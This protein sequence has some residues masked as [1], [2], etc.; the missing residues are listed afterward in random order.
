MYYS[1][2][3]SFCSDIYKEAFGWDLPNMHDGWLEGFSSP[4]R[5]GNSV[6]NIVMQY[7]Q[8]PEGKKSWGLEADET[9]RD[10]DQ[11]L[12][13]MQEQIRPGD[14]IYGEKH[15]FTNGGHVLMF[16][17]D[18]FGDG[19]DYCLHSWP[20]GGGIMGS[21]GVNKWEPNGSATLQK[22]DEVLFNTKTSHNGADGSPNW[23]VSAKNDEGDPNMYYVWLIR[24]L[25]NENL[26][27]SV[28]PDKTITRLQYPFLSVEKDLGMYG[29][30]STFPGD[31]I[32]VRETVTSHRDAVYE[33]V[34]LSEKIPAGTKLVAGSVTEGGSEKDGVISWSFNVAAGDSV[35]VSYQL[36]VTA[37]AG[38]TLSFEA[39]RLNDLPTR[40]EE[41]KVGASRLTEAQ[42]KRLDRLT[43]K[44]TAD[45]VPDSFQNLDYVN[46]FYKNVL[47]MDIALPDNVS[48]VTE[49]LL[50]RCKPSADYEGT[51]LTPKK[52]VEAKYQTLAD[53]TV[54]RNV[55]GFHIYLEDFLQNKYHL[56]DLKQEFYQPGDVIIVA[57]HTADPK[58]TLADNVLR[59][60]I[61]LGHGKLV[62]HKAASTK[63]VSW[64]STV[65][66]DLLAGLYL[67]LRPAQ[68]VDA[69]KAPGAYD[70][71][72]GPADPGE[73][74]SENLATRAAVTT[75][76]AMVNSGVYPLSMLN[77]GEHID[78]TNMAALK[79]KEGGEILFDLGETCQITGYNLWMYEW[80]KQY[81]L[82]TG[83]E[84]YASAD[85]S[86]YAKI[87]SGSID[88]SVISASKYASEYKGGT[89]DGETFTDPVT[90]RYI[91]LVITSC[92]QGD[93]TSTPHIRLY[94]VDILGYV[95]EAAPA[96]E[97]PT[98]NL[99]LSANISTTYGLASFHSTGAGAV[100]VDAKY[101]IQNIIDGDFSANV[102]SSC[103]YLWSPV[104]YILLDLGG[105]HTLTGYRIYNFQYPYQWCINKAWTVYGSA[106]GESW[107]KLA[108]DEIDCTPF[109]KAVNYY[110][111]IKN[112]EPDGTDFE[113]FKGRY[114]KLVIDEV[115]VGAG[116]ASGY[117]KE[118][119]SSRDVRIYEFEV[120]GH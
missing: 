44:L 110:N 55:F 115:F 11:F 70:D 15:A 13:D 43:T 74:K 73:K 67:V 76:Y 63:L 119:T 87:G 69:T 118:N 68:G 25:Q 64:A 21:D 38:E 1:H 48:E 107:T 33:N 29:T 6:K 37:K 56:L 80:W 31:I 7:T 93:K 66:K 62:E 53:M 39:G 72:V 65:Q 96:E 81:G 104:G 10:I 120:L 112:G 111:A 89:P 105:E 86:E 59:I 88:T 77:D 61:Y 23:S 108:H 41:I 71:P 27:G 114:V 83:W 24:P 75:S 18:V 99:A 30:G 16:L 26:N 106:D 109:S 45:L 82:V 92:F 51:M 40:C 50:E 14:I 47:G 22:A 3:R 42:L 78:T 12:K 4:N 117:D 17:G 116:T 102:A 84:V 19:E 36:E 103:R 52:T 2:C 57:E 90:A 91:K 34:A 95:G 32:T 100:G 60:C 35:T 85:G 5:Y 54:R 113:P 97:E 46:Q 79:F 9:Y 58:Y 98:R 8:L 20:V 28:I 94:D 49:A 101:P